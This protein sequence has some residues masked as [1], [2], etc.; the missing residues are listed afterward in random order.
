MAGPSVL[1]VKSADVGRMLLESN[2]DSGFRNF[3]GS[4]DS[5]VGYA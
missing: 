2:D 3:N 4:S 5:D 1:Q